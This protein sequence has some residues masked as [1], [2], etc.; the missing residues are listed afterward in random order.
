M[1]KRNMSRSMSIVHVFIMVFFSPVSFSKQKTYYRS[2]TFYSIET[3]QTFPRVTPGVVFVFGPDAM[4]R[5]SRPPPMLSLL[6]LVRNT[7]TRI[8]V[9]IYIYE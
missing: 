3:K 8:H 4:R 2:A 5:A 1:L 6:L 7:R 9:Y